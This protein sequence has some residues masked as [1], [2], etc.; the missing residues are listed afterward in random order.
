[1]ATLPI[2]TTGACEGVDMSGLFA[3]GALSALTGIGLLVAMPLSAQEYPTKPVRI[4]TAGAG[5]FHDVTARQLAQRL[6]ERWRQ[7]VVVENQPAAGLTIGTSIAAK[8]SPDGYTLLLAD[9]TSLA[10]APHLY[11]EFSLRSRE[12]PPAHHARRAGALG[13]GH[14]LFRARQQC[15]RIHRLCRQAERA[16]PLRIR[17]PRDARSPDR[18]VVQAHRGH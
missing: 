16:G 17:R 5:T 14:S 8:A 15:A 11:K 10:V 4:I 7:G 13:S 2:S 12:G 1:M 9:R 18:R 6:S 3:A